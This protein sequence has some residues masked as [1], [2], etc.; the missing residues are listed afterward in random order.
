MQASKL[1][2]ELKERHLYRVAVIYGAAAWLLLQIAD[3]IAE[4][5]DWPT[6]LM[7]G[8]IVALI[9]GLPAVMLFFWFAG[10]SEEGG[11][12]V[13]RAW[14]WAVRAM[15]GLASSFCLSIAFPT[16]EK[17]VGMP[18]RYPKTSQP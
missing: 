1:L 15:P 14:R 10:E 12:P 17:T 11:A 16:R 9:F 4:S 3:I 2:A 6:W 5:F 18:M 8:L 13:K 7:Q